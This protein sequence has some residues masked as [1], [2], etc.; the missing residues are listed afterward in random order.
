MKESKGEF[1]VKLLMT[2]AVAGLGTSCLGHLIDSQVLAE[3][4]MFI[5]AVSLPMMLLIAI[6]IY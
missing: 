5:L 4:G 1:Y 6:W 2:A 3:I